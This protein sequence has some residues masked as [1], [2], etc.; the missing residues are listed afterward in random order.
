MNKMLY[1]FTTGSAVLA[2]ILVVTNLCLINGNQ[3]IQQDI[4]S[5]QNEINIAMNVSPINQQLAQALFDASTKAKDTQI[6]DLLISQ[7]FEV[8]D[9]A[10]NQVTPEA[11]APV[12]PAKPVKAKS[13]TV[14]E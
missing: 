5:R 2:F 3:A 6:R 7:G 1:W 4:A 8:K 9:K 10:G 11:K 13:Q 12:A 14:E